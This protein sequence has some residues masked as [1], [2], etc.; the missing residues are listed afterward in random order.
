MGGTGTID[1]PPSDDRVRAGVAARE[2]GEADP[3]A[4]PDGAGAHILLVEDTPS[5][6]ALY[7]EWLKQAGLACDVAETG[8][9]AR[10]AL[11]FGRYH[12]VLLDLQLPDMNGMD[13]LKWLR[14]GALPVPVVVITANGSISTAIEAMRHGAHDF[15]VKPFN[16]RRLVTTVRNAVTVGDLKE[17][18]D[19]L[20]DEF[21]RNRFY[22][23]IGRSLAMQGVYRTIE[24]VARSNAT[25]FIT[26]ESGTGK[27]VCAEAI[28]RAG[29]RRDKP[30]VPVNCAAIP[31]D[32]IE[33]EL[34]GHLKGAFTGAIADRDGAATQASGGTLFLDEICEMDVAL[35]TKLLRF[36]QTGTLQRVGGGHQERVD[37]RVVCATNRDP[38]DEV[39]AGRFRED[40]FFR[41]Y[42]VP[43]HL[44]PL[45]E[46]TDDVLEIAEALLAQYAE[47]EGRAFQGFEP[48]AAE[49][50][51]AH[52]WPGNVR[53]LQNVIRSIVVLHE[54]P[55][56][57]LAM[58]PPALAGRAAPLRAQTVLPAETV[59]Q[60]VPRGVPSVALGR[61]LWEIEKDAIEMTIAMCG[62]SVPKAARILGISSSTIYR[63]R[64][65]WE[66]GD[67]AL[68]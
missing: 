39:R 44:P 56:V 27:E 59:T 67:T 25:V 41:L 60:G 46:R 48:E 17:Q 28:H 3:S 1:R 49:A 32:L 10:N 63:K 23:F 40:L 58:L 21:G 11:E 50:L 62:G 7:C 54:G 30:F 24:T 37:V 8:A 36:L 20:R 57:T 14:D 18:V 61:E 26:G 16:E 45:R 64:Q 68:P 15:L 6:A 47:E 22:G 43:I 66:A 19:R 31:R 35:Q 52:S 12:L 53:E 38:Q 5:L 29:P 2:A 4:G 65:A 51:A 55:D 13:I 34:F 33:S 42:V 9:K